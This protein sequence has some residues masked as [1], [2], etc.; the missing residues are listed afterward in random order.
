MK[1]LAASPRQTRSGSVL[2]AVLWLIAILAMASVTALRVVSYDADLASAKIGGF[3][4]QQLAEKGV[5]IAANPAV[6]RNDPLLQ[7]I[8]EKTGE[9]FRVKMTSEGGK[10]NLNYIILKG[11][12]PL[13]QEIFINWGL[14]ME[15]AQ[16]L[17]DALI[18]WVDTND[19]TSLN[20]AE[21][22]WYEKQGRIN[23]PF[24]RPFYDIEEVRLVKGMDRVEALKPD[25]RDWFTIWSSG[26][27]DCNEA[28][29]ELIAAATEIPVAEARVIT[30]T[31]L[32]PD[33]IRDTE[34][35]KP[36]QNVEAVLKQLG[37]NTELRPDISSRVTVNDSTTRIE[38][39][40]VTAGATRK[41]VLTVRSRTGRPAILDRTE[42]VTP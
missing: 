36:Y 34:D 2:I 5:A 40:G 4:A 18:D 13:L 39:T 22:E 17:V 6:K 35:D 33:G 28:D 14:Q 1:R 7:Q 37:V 29:P 24:N 15:E 31:V 27:L 10:F 16:A 20:G 9:G 42:E 38:S 8:D 30:E 19:E 25:W 11:D 26:P 21:K 32:G 23:Q 12:K 41:I 3:Q